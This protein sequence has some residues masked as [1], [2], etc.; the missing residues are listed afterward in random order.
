MSKFLENMMSYDT[1]TENGAV[2]HSTTGKF[3]LDYFSKAGTYRNRTEEEVFADISKVYSESPELALRI[4]LYLRNITRKQKGF[5]E[6]DT[7]QKGQGI[8]DEFIK[9]VKWFEIYHSEDLYNNL[10]LIPL[11]GTWKDLWYDSAYSGYYH[12]VNEKFVFPLIKKGLSD[13]YNRGLLAKYLPRI[14]S[15]SNVKNGRHRRLNRFAKNL[16]EYLEWSEKDYRK[17]KSD[18]E[19]QAHLFQRYMSKN[20]WDKIDFNTIP[21]KALFKLINNKGRD[22]KT[23]FQRHN[24]EENF[25]EWVKNQPTVKFT[26]YIYELLRSLYTNNSLIN[27]ITIDKQFEGLLK[28]AEKSIEGNVLVALDTSG[29][30]GTTIPNTDIS[31][32]DICIS[33]GIYF[34]SLNTGAFKDTVVMFDNV[35]RTMKLGGTFSQKVDQIKSSSI[36]WGS[37]NF[38]SVIDEIV[39]VRKSKPEIPVEE[40]PETLIVVSD[41]QFNPAGDDKTN[42]EQAMKK[43]SDAGLNKMNIIWWYVHGRSEEFPNKFDDEG[44]TIISGFDPLVITT[45]L[46]RETEIVDKTTKKVRKL[47]PYENMIKTLNQDY[48]NQ[49]KL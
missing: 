7:V 48:L 6:S 45:L 22:G 38:Q 15:K 37:T 14:R 9:L 32:Y 5:F 42:Y 8:K 23:A 33:L 20:Y 4:M 44:V 18:P 24:V 40:Y 25:I 11:T 29:S 16:I 30:M 34:S 27:R 13:E 43:L 28:L 17:F 35:S 1:I 2:S 12:Y 26:G 47:N 39:R 3:S 10:W 41:M 19:N 21:G 46:G 31:A 49:I 36:A